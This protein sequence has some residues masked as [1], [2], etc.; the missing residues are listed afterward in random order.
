MAGKLRLELGVL[1][2]KSLRSDEE[3]QPF[4]SSWLSKWPKE[5]PRF[6]GERSEWVSS[7]FRGPDFAS[8]LVSEGGLEVRA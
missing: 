1:N 8:G 6:R 7:S 4:R 2:G 5:V 3:S